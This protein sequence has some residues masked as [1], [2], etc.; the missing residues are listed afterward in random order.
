MSP[1]SIST[2]QPSPYGSEL[3]S[4]GCDS[5]A[6]LRAST[7]PATGAKTSETLLVDSTSPIGCPAVTAVPTPGSE[8]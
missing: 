2:I 4:S 3:S 5:R 8:T 1:T 7:V 6:S